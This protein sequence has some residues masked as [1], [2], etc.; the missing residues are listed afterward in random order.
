MPI[1]K[2]AIARRWDIRRLYWIEEGGSSSHNIRR[3]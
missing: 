3:K 1:Q 2:W